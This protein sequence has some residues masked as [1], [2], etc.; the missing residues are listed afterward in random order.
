MGAALSLHLRGSQSRAHGSGGGGV[1]ASDPGVPIR[2]GIIHALLPA[3][4][5]RPQIRHS[6]R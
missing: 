4:P 1:C 5:S 6:C 3:L 2:T